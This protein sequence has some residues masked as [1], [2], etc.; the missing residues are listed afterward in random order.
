MQIHLLIA[1]VPSVV[2]HEARVAALDLY[3]ASSL[4]LNVLDVGSTLTNDLGSEVEAWDGFEIYG[5]LFFG[6]FS[7]QTVNLGSLLPVECNSRGLFHH[8]QTAQA[9]G[10]ETCARQSSWADLAASWRQFRRRP[11]QALLGSG[12]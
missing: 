7:L 9:H 5:N 2:L 8:A 1:L 12:S 11:F 10:V 4:L 6:P 3:T